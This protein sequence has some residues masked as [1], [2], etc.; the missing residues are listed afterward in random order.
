VIVPPAMVEIWEIQGN[1]V[2][3]PFENLQVITE[4]NVVTAVAGNG[5]FIQT[6]AARIDG[7]PATS[8]GIFVFTNAA[9]A[10]AVGDQVDVAGTIVEFFELTEFSD[11]GL[12]VTV[13]SSGN[14]LP[15]PISLDATTPSMV[16]MTPHDLERFEG[17]LVTVTGGVASGP[18]DNFGDL[19]IVA[20]AALGRGFR[21]PGLEFPGMPGLPVWDGNPEVFDVN[22]DGL[23]LPNLS[24][25]AGGSIDFA[26]GPLSFAFGDYSLLPSAITV[27]GAPA[28]RPVRDRLPGELTVATQNMLRLFDDSASPGT[29]DLQIEK[30]SIQVREV[31]GAPDVLGV[32]EVG[33]LAALQELAARI[34]SDDPTVVYTAHLLEG[35]DIGGI[36]VGFLV[37]DTVQVDSVTQ[38]GLT[39]TFVFGGTTFLTHD[40]PPLIL[41]GQYLGNGDPFP[42]T[43]IVNHLRSLSGIEGAEGPRIRAKRNEQATRISELIQATQTTFPDRPLIVTGDFNAF[44]FTDGYVHVMGQL[45]GDPADASQALIPGTDEV[46]PN[47]TNQVLSLPPEERY[48]FNFGGNAQALDHTL[49][50][51]A[52]APFVR[53]VAFSRGNSD[54]PSSF[55]TVP[56]TAL[57]SS[58]HDGLVLYLMSDRDADGAPDDADNCPDTFNPGQEDDDSDGLGDACDSCTGTSIPEATVPSSELGLFRYALVDGDFTFDTRVPPG[59]P[60]PPPVYT[61]QDTGGCSCE[62]ILAQIRHGRGEEFFGCRRQTLN[63]WIYGSQVEP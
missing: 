39:D 12:T 63:R 49:T 37:R 58:D 41:E 40:R 5:F 10:V 2:A 16:P 33:E 11:V 53:G 44:A 27:S 6:P 30:L 60:P 8:D 54:V 15:A 56:G 3:S 31:L 26:E 20:S 19:P 43:V 47:L 24:V 57:R 52:T 62:Q 38:F 25:P 34:Q 45:V 28:S 36:D 35:N 13:D 50:S 55:G 23:G 59:N 17:M 7:D 61:L 46:E 51:E 21:E 42:L 32:Q 1:G 29:N 14:P 4:D 48:S 22:P 18:S 9:P